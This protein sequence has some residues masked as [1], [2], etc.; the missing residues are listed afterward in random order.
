M[1][2]SN[3]E[4]QG[5]MT[6]ANFFS[7]AAFGE[8]TR[9]SPRLRFFEKYV[10]TVDD[11]QNNGGSVDWTKFYKPNAVFHNADG[12]DYI[13]NA[14]ISEWINTLFGGF[15]HLS[16]ENNS[17]LEV[18]ENGGVGSDG[19]E[20]DQATRWHLHADFTRILSLKKWGDDAGK[21]R[22]PMGAVWTIEQWEDG[23]DGYGFG[24]ATMWWDRSVL[25]MGPPSR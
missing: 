20:G 7:P 13:G 10:S 14:A 4:T 8:I 19:G 21:R 1:A 17:F 25:S 12:I 9:T 23:T 15:S 2:S 3:T 5:T 24:K 11:T 16:H 22:V 6:V 18:E